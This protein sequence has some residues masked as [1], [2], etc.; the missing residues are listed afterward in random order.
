VIHRQEPY[1]HVW[2]DVAGRSYHKFLGRPTER[3]NRIE[4]VGADGIFQYWVSVPGKEITR[5]K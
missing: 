5:P 2:V 3:P 4:Q 1:G